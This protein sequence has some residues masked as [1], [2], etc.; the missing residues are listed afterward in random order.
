MALCAHVV[1]STKRELHNVWKRL[2]RSEEDRSTA[3]AED[4]TMQLRTED[5]H[6]I[7]R[8]TPLP[9]TGGGR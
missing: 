5:A 6:H 9:Y 8:N 4:Q 2:Q 1:S 3:I 7:M